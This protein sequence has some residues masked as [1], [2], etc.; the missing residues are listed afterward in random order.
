MGKREKPLGI[1]RKKGKKFEWRGESSLDLK[2]SVQSKSIFRDKRLGE[3]N[4]N[5]S[6]EDKSLLRYQR[7][8]ELKSKR[9]QRFELDN[10]LE[11]THK[12]VR[13]SDLHDDY[14]EDYDIDLSD[15]ETKPRKLAKMSDEIVDQFHF[16]DGKTRT[17]KDAYEEIIQKSKYNKLIRQQEKEQNFE[18][19][20]KIDDEF[21]DIS[22][23]LR[24]KDK[25]KVE[26]KDE[27]DDLMMEI[28]DDAKMVAE[29]RGDGKVKELRKEMEERGEDWKVPDVFKE[30]V[31]KVRNDP[32]TGVKN[33]K[34]WSDCEVRKLRTEVQEK[35]LFYSLKYF[36]NEMVDGELSVFSEM[37]EVLYGLC[38]E[39]QRPAEKY[40]MQVSETF[41]ESVNLS[42]PYFYHLV[43]LLFPLKFEDK[44]S[45]N[46]AYYV[47]DLFVD[48]PLHSEKTIR[49][50]L[51][52]SKV[53]LDHWLQK[54]F[55]PELCRFLYKV[56]SLPLSTCESLNQYFP[57]GVKPYTQLLISKLSQEF[58]QFSVFQQ[59]FQG[60]GL[61]FEDSLKVP[62]KL[63]E[64]PIEEIQTF[65]PLVY[66]NVRS[67]KKNRDV[68][69]EVTELDRLREQQKRA[70]KLAKKTLEKETELNQYEKSVEFDARNQVYEKKQGLVKNM[71]DELQ[72]EYKKFDTSMEKRKEKKKRKERM[73]GNW[74]EQNKGEKKGRSKD[75]KQ[76]YKK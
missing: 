62:L 17:K 72:A 57:Q 22:R 2:R 33:M 35:L 43:S 45:L 59:I 27:F 58:G 60:F 31:F 71:L 25:E 15:E 39:Y 54:K 32:V 75:K 28:R 67:N 1:K 51:F 44:L 14:V 47:C 18:I 26:E 61:E 3:K 23:R 10:D 11:L 65:E 69:K 5:L 8:R 13:L 49:N 40:F 46:L 21:E 55:S 66:D 24:F 56:M 29:G 68:N 48:F 16:G 34:V 73:G 7:E 38:K 12:G 50:L 52:L 63:Y 64:R 74:T 41:P 19:T 20:K 76:G 6:L 42:L 70:R 53:F 9:K 36:V 37:E 30:F 4:P